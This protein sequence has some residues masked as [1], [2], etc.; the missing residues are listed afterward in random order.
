MNRDMKQAIEREMAKW[1]GVE[2]AIEHRG[3]HPA[4]VVRRGGASRFVPFTNTRTD[5]RG[6]LNK[7]SDIRRALREIGCTE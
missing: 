1:P 4:L 2:Y 5:R 3:K 7:V 6:I